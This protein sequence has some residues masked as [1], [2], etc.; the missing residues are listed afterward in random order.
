MIYRDVYRWFIRVFIGGL[1]GCLSVVYW[2]V[3]RWFIGVLK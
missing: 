1:L 3:Y 2:G